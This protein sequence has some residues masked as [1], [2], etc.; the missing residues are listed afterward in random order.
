MSHIPLFE[1]LLAEIHRGLGL[2][3]PDSK[4]RFTSGGM[5]TANH[6]ALEEKLVEEVFDSLGL[7]ENAREDAILN[8]NEFGFFYKALALRISTYEA[9]Q[10]QVL[11]HLLAYVLLPGVARRVAFWALHNEERGLPAIDAGMP[12]GTFWFLPVWDIDKDQVVMPVTQV[13]G[14]LLDLLDTKKLRDMDRLIGPKGLRHEGTE[15]AIRTLQ[16]WYKGGVPKSAE[17]IGQIFPDDAAL[18]FPGAFS[19]DETLSQ[20]ELFQAA[21]DFAARKDLNATSLSRQIPMNKE[22]LSIVLTGAASN[23]EQQHFVK[24]LARRY[25]IPSM[26]VVRRRLRVARLMQEGFERLLKFLHELAPKDCP[27]ETT[28]NKAL[29]LLSVFSFV[30]NQTVAAYK[31]GGPVWQ[32]DAWFEKKL[33][34]WDAGDLF[35]SILPSLIGRMPVERILADRLSRIFREQ[36]SC[37]QIED[38]APLNEADPNLLPILKR[39]ANRVRRFIDEDLRSADLLEQVKTMAPWRALMFETGFQVLL[40]FVGNVDSKEM[41]KLGLDRL[42]DIAATPVEQTAVEVL[43]LYYLLNDLE[44]PWPQEAQE[45]AQSILDRVERSPGYELWKAPVLRLKALHHLFQN[46]FAAAK[47][48]MDEALEACSERAYGLERGHI[49]TEAFAITIVHEGLNPRTHL[50]YYGQILRFREEFLIFRAPSFDDVAAQCEDVFWDE[51]YRPYPGF[52]PR[53]K[54]VK[55]RRSLH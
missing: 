4:G 10:Q 46:D 43:A 24:C 54:E 3:R 37:S 11:W 5:Q 44:H 9:S 50:P 47:Q 12:G 40:D 55:G 34:P 17:K 27:I 26:S 13:L 32:Q 45:Q 15:S 18:V 35:I 14:W 42:R 29:Q 16:N 38:L 30:Y 52:E 20:D 41:R 25:A 1:E 2:E 22:R 8:V 53:R 28:R 23:E 48:F 31:E 39:R 7:D 36:L 33:A 51:L 6:K 49:A 21:I 19:L